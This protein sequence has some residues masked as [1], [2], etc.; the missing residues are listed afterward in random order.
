MTQKETHNFIIKSLEALNF[1]ATI[2]DNSVILTH[3]NQKTTIWYSEYKK[4]FIFY[5]D[6]K[7]K[8]LDHSDKIELIKHIQKPNNVKV[9]SVKKVTDWLNY[10][11][12][13]KTILD[14]KEQEISL[15]IANFKEQVSKLPHEVKYDNSGYIVKNGLEYS[16]N[17]FDSGYIEQKIRVRGNQDLESFLILTK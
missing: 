3:E 16:Y 17:I 10:L 1:K 8:H 9:L 12:E 14:N 7:Y 2:D 15:K 13:C 4:N 5:L 6:T 11:I